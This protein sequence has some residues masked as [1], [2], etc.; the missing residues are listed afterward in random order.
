MAFSKEQKAVIEARENR[1]VVIASSGSG[2]TACLVERTKQLLKEV[3]DSSKI[4]LITFTNAAAEEMRLRI[5]DAKNIFIGTI[6]S[7]ANMLLASTSV[8]TMDIIEAEQYDKL[9]EKAIEQPNCFKEVEHL[10]LDEAQDTSK[11]QMSF[12]L[13]YVKPKNFF[14]VGDYRQCIYEFNG[15]DPK[16]LLKLKRNEKFTTYYLTQNYRTSK[17]ILIYAK[18]IIAKLGYDFY[19]DSICMRNNEGKVLER[20]C[21]LSAIFKDIPKVGE[22]KDWFILC[23][24][25]AQVDEAIETLKA[26]NIPYDTFKRAELNEADYAIKMRSN[27][28]K[29]LTSHS[30]K[31]LENKNV[32]VIGAMWGSAEEIRLNYVSATRAKNLLIWVTSNDF[33]SRQ[34][35]RSKIIKTVQF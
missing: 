33:N 30:S 11:L 7:Y 1:I 21:G 32:I 20:S 13:D 23:R 18:K 15:V 6:H 9:L 22:L 8:N 26:L 34:R 24:S 25:N 12:I 3:E 4:V 16:T 10:L 5:G 17:S 27:T 31:G 28:V 14:A 29:V 19:D 35:C 2:K